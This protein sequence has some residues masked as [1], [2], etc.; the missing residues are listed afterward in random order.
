MLD[1]VDG[2][3]ISLSA[4]VP[5]VIS[6]RKKVFPPKFEPTP[7]GKQP[8]AVVRPVSHFGGHCCLGVSKPVPADGYSS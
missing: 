1:A 6:A 2:V 4:R 3:V 5:T 7:M 8:T